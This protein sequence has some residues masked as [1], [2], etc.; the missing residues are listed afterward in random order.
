LPLEKSMVI[1]MEPKS[2]I[3]GVAVVGIENTFLV[4]QKGLESLTTF[5]DEIVIL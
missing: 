1:A 2:V 5:K 4:T 3:P